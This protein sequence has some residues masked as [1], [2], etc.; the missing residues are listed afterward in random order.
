MSEFKEKPFIICVD[1]EQVILDSLGSQLSRGYQNQFDVEVAN[2]VEEAWE[3]ID[4]LK[5]SG[6]EIRLI[7]CDW[8]M[9]PH[10]GDQFLEEV[11]AKNPNIKLALLTGH[12]DERAVERVRKIPNCLGVLRK[13]WT[14][15][16]LFKLV[17]DSEQKDVLEA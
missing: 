7:I 14:R 12:A 15:E 11:Y 9:T 6:N 5:S 8:L 4:D 1:D 17:E 13:P 16:D 3:I 10:L 2:G